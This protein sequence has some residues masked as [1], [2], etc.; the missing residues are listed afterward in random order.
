MND[1]RKSKNQQREEARKAK[2]EQSKKA[3]AP[4]HKVKSGDTLYSISQRYGVSVEQLCK[5]NR[6]GKKMHIRP[7][8]VL[9]CS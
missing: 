7:G 6:I 9:R 5:M 1:S 2:K 4:T 8:Q 3:A